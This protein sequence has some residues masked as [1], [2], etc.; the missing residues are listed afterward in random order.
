MKKELFTTKTVVAIGIGAALF[1][2]LG[3]F[4]AIPSG[5]QNT[6]FALQYG[7]LA[8]MSALFGPVAGALIGFIGHWLIDLTA[9]WG[10]WWTWVIASAVNGAIS[11]LAADKI[12]LNK[13]KFET[14]EIITFVVINLIASVLCWLVVAPVGDIVIMSEDAATVYAQGVFAAIANFIV[15]AVVGGLLCFGYTKTVAKEGS[16]DKE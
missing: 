13:G 11:G 16:L 9:G 4:V 12:K 5:I 10:V 6:N 3:K 14:K 2:V 1:F 7:V 8:F 15:S